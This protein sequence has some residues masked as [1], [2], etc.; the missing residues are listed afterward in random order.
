MAHEQIWVDNLIVVQVTDRS[1]DSKKYI[2]FFSKSCWVYQL[3]F[4]WFPILLETAQCYCSMIILFFCVPSI[5]APDSFW[6]CSRDPS[7][8]TQG[9]VNLVPLGKKL[10]PKMAPL[11]GSKTCLQ[12]FIL[13][14]KISCKNLLITKLLIKKRDFSSCTVGAPSR[15]HPLWS[16]V[17][18]PWR[19]HCQPPTAW[20]LI[21][22]VQ[23]HCQYV[24]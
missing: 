18:S 2:W 4:H 11:N 17:P 13:G 1:S 22:V 7:G 6:W 9:T 14:Q 19:P 24:R 23:L 16:G 5:S 10:Q 12:C 20:P 21:Q 15:L 8:I 3:R